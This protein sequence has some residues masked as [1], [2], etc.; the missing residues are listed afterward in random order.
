MLF[1]EKVANLKITNASLLNLTTWSFYFICLAAIKLSPY[2]VNLSLDHSKYRLHN[3]YYSPNTTRKKRWLGNVELKNEYT[4]PI[5]KS[6]GKRQLA[7]YWH[8][9]EVNIKMDLNET[10]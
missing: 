3:L 9:W 5:R 8:R 4:T 10:V 2:H 6:E 1:Y 7:R